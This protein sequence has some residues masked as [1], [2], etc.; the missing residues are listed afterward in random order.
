MSSDVTERERETRT[1]K[2][3]FTTIVKGGEREFEL[4]LEN[5]ILQR[6]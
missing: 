3:Y 6:L 5:F 1:R 2:L 4:E